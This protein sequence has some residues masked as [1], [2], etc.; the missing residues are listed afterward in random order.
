[1]PPNPRMIEDLLQMRRIRPEIRNI[2]NVGHGFLS[3]IRPPLT[4]EKVRRGK[5]QDDAR[6]QQFT[7]LGVLQDVEF[8]LSKMS[9]DLQLC[10]CL[11]GHEINV[12]SGW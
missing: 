9:F 7:A 4:D 11:D 2:R 8:I 3:S 5:P 6:L 1:M 10:A 12:E